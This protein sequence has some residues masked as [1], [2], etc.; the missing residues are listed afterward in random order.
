MDKKWNQK[1][2]ISSLRN[3]R[4]YSYDTSAASIYYSWSN[5]DGKKYKI[6]WQNDFYFYE[7][8]LITAGVEFE[9]EETSSEYYLFTICL[10]L[11]T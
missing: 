8:N 2:G 7:N 1:L 4:N 9:L 10:I 6:D 5:Y 3:I 11:F